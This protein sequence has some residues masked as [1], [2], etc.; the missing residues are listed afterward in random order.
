MC[1]PR[2]PSPLDFC[3]NT[4]MDT[5]RFLSEV[6]K[7][8]HTML[9]CFC[10]QR[11]LLHGVLTR[12]QISGTSI[13]N[14]PGCPCCFSIA[15]IKHQPKTTGQE[16]I[17]LAHMAQW[18]SQSVI[19][20]CRGRKLEAGAKAKAMEH[21]LL[22]VCSTCFLIRPRSTSLPAQGWHPP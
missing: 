22:G 3:R 18:P 17:F 8:Y 6:D 1:H 16:G 12:P 7:V 9:W 15:A 14:T 19:K 5:Q 4:L 2:F 21:L 13:V 11:E 20:G 10:L